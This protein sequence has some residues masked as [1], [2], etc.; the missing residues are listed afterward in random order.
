MI[1]NVFLYGQLEDLELALRAANKARSAAEAEASEALAA[2]EEASR[3]KNEAAER[4]HAAGRDAAAARAQLDDAEEE[5]AEVTPFTR[6]L[7]HSHCLHIRKLI[8]DTTL[9]S[10]TSDTHYRLYRRFI[11][12]ECALDFKST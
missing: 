3:A 5:A 7:A 12:P 10:Y 4:A 11:I 6:T 2:A 8:S 1:L 9:G